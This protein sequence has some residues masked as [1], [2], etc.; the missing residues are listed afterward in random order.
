MLN[1]KKTNFV[2]LLRKCVLGRNE[3]ANQKELNIPFAR[4]LNVKTVSHVKTVCHD[5]NLSPLDSNLDTKW[6]CQIYCILYLVIYT[7][8]VP[9]NRVRVSPPPPITVTSFFFKI[10]HVFCHY[11]SFLTVPLRQ[12]LK[13]QR[14]VRIKFKDTMQWV[15]YSFEDWWILV[16]IFGSLEVYLPNIKESIIRTRFVQHSRNLIHN[17]CKI[18]QVYIFQQSGDNYYIETEQVKVIQ[19]RWNLERHKQIYEI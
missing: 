10:S 8:Q 12:C 2:N 11:G 9:G 18:S 19:K 17:Q 14:K 4:R 1:I 5:N 6:L 13:S 7:R 15:C 3:G 16:E